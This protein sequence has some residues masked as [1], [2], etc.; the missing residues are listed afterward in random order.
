MAKR[1]GGT[2]LLRQAFE[3]IAYNIPKMATEE[4]VETLF[5]VL[6]GTKTS[7]DAATLLPSQKVLQNLP[8][9]ASN[10]GWVIAKAW[11]EWWRR[12][13]HLGMFSIARKHS[14]NLDDIVTDASHF[15]LCCPLSMPQRHLISFP[16]FLTQPMPWKHTIVCQRVVRLLNHCQL[17]SCPCI[18]RIWWLSWRVWQTMWGISTTYMDR[19]PAAREKRNKH[20]NAARNKRQQKDKDD[21]QGPP[22][23]NSDFKKPKKSK[24][25]CVYNGTFACV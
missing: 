20:S 21:A 23:R 13:K 22:D 11:S 9:E 6:Q 2:T 4:A 14:G 1:V 18:R 19:T 8:P 17:R 25:C 5:D 3:C 10:K 15:Q 24:V 16:S 7:Q 12:L